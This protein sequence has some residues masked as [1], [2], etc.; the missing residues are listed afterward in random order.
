MHSVGQMGTIFTEQHM[1]IL[2][3]YKKGVYNEGITL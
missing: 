1:Q 2:V 3:A